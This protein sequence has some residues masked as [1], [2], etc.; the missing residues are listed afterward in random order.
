MIW[1]TPLQSQ[2]IAWVGF[3]FLIKSNIAFVY[4]LKIINYL[5]DIRG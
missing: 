5:N 1:A 4:Q 2:N 3:T